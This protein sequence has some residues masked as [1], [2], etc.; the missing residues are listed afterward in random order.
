M[1]KKLTPEDLEL[2]K[3]MQQE[4]RAARERA[5]ERS[6]PLPPASPGK[7]DYLPGLD[8]NGAFYPAE[9]IPSIETEEH[10]MVGPKDDDELSDKFDGEVIGEVAPNLSPESLRALEILRKAS[11]ERD[12]IPPE[13]RVPI[14][15]PRFY[16]AIGFTDGGEE[17]P[18][19]KKKS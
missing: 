10:R 3:K 11:A 12:K 18:A 19:N 7:Y 17:L 4:Y 15:N 13:K 8:S 9:E 1:I 6:D 16:G 2:F 5:A 14:T